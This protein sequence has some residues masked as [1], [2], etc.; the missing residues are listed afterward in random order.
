M[1]EID[2]SLEYLYRSVRKYSDRLLGFGWVDPHFGIKNGKETIK[3]CLE[4]YGFYGIKLNGAQNSYYIDDKEMSL[5]LIE[6]VAK[7]GS[8][9]AFHIGADAYDYTHPLRAARVAEKFPDLPILMVH[10]GGVNSPDLTSVCIE[11]ASIYSNMYL[12]GSC[13]RY[14]S[15]VKAI[16]VLGASR[17]SFGSDTPF[18][19]MHA[20]VCAYEAFLQ[21]Y[22]KPE[23]RDLVMG[24][25]IERLFKLS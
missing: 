14:N 21:D 2:A 8:L 19:I 11:Y 23:E 10:M 22:F 25:N 15:V 4:E 17:I 5:P 20:D 18:S 9:L 13:V 1:R 6:E 3:K 24:G 16:R 7:S 12:I